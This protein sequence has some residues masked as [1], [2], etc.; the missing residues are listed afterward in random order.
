MQPYFDLCV[1]KYLFPPKPTN[2]P[3]CFHLIKNE[4]LLYVINI[5]KDFWVSCFEKPAFYVYFT[6]THT[7]SKRN[8]LTLWVYFSFMWH[9]FF[10]FHIC[11]FGLI[12][13][14]G[15]CFAFLSDTLANARTGMCETLKQSWH[16]VTVQTEAAVSCFTMTVS[17][18]KISSYFSRKASVKPGKCNVNQGCILL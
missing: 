11:A 1:P 14:H 9:H 13:V 2:W 8:S 16:P 10:F 18:Y 12:A 15:K 4:F 7:C 3:F 5:T 6:H 17:V